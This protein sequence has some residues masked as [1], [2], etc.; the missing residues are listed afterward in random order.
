ML[1]I[2]CSFYLLVFTIAIEHV[3]EST[4]AWCMLPNK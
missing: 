2:G 4:N 3:L 1:T